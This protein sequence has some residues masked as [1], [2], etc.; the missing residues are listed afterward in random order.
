MFI[1]KAILKDFV[2][3]EMVFHAKA[4]EGFTECFQSLCD[5]KEDADLEVN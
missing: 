3:I 4:L 1:Y 5:I 2:N